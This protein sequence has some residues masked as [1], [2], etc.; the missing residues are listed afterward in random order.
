MK[1]NE[2]GNIEEHEYEEPRPEDFLFDEEDEDSEGV[3]K[4]KRRKAFM[5]KTGAIV[6][7]FFLVINVLGVWFNMF[8]LDALQFLRKSNELSEQEDIQLYK[9]AVVTIQADHAKGTGFAVSPDGLIITNHHVIDGK[10]KF[11]VSFP[12]GDLYEGTVIDSNEELDLAFVHVSANDVPYLTLEDKSGKIGDEIYVIGNP[13]MHSQIV[14]NGQIIENEDRLQVLKISA[15]IYSGNSGSP[16]I[17]ENGKVIGVVYARTVP[18][19]LDE[20]SS[21]GLAVPIQYVNE[22][23]ERLVFE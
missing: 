13:L 12:N 5:I 11:I 9:E 10:G 14:T 17:N 22:E 8:S 18:S 4:Q 16:V 6:I 20:E 7:S 21:V 3:E 19:L 23:L 15:P 2:N 1:D